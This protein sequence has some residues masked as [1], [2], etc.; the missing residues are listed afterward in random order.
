MLSYAASSDLQSAD[1]SRLMSVSV[2]A[3]LCP[4]WSWSSGLLAPSRLR[5][6]DIFHITGAHTRTLHA[7][8]TLFSDC[9]NP[10]PQATA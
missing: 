10:P 8:A 7:S 9:L 1:G 4:S 3:T 2:D 6:E 5:K